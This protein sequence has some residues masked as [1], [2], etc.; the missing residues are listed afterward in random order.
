MNISLTDT[1][2]T[3]SIYLSEDFE[4]LDEIISLLVKPVLLAAGFCEAQLDKHFTPD[5]VELV[6]KDWGDN[7]EVAANA[8]PEAAPKVATKQPPMEKVV[9][10]KVAPAAK[11]A[12]AKMAG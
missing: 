8:A 10:K 5:E 11:Q 4:T 12:T 7:E 2:G 6:F 9:C 1:N 3:Y